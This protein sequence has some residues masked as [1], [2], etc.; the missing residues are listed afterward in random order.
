MG[1]VGKYQCGHAG[2]A[3][4]DSHHRLFCLRIAVNADD[5]GWYVVFLQETDNCSRVQTVAG[6]V[7]GQ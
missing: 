4:I 1:P 6:C 2:I 5:F 7:N 3:I